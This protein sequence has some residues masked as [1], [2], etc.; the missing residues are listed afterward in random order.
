MGG[1]DG[2]GGSAVLAPCALRAVW[3]IGIMESVEVVI[4]V[5]FGIGLAAKFF[6]AAVE[7]TLFIRSASKVDERQQRD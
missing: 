7:A 1:A 3:P 6:H 2:S 5:Y 4:V